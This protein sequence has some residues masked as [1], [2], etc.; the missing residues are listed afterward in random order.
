[1]T[2]GR[3]LRV[4]PLHGDVGMRV[5]GEVDMTNQQVWA[6]TVEPLS[7]SPAPTT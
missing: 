1:M 4:F 5:V 7:D 3:T 2:D 6:T